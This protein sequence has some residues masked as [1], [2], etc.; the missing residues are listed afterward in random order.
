MAELLKDIYNRDFLRGLG[1][2]ILSVYGSFDAAALA[3]LA[4]GSEWEKTALKA[5]MRKI[6]E[7]LGDLLPD[8]YEDALDILFAIADDCAGFPYLI[9]PDFVA[10]RGQDEADWELSMRALE[11][12]TQK[13]S[14]EFAIRPFIQKNPARV[15]DRMLSWA[16]HPNEHVRRFSSEGCRPR[17][18]WGEALPVFKKDPS[19]VLDILERLKTDG[20]LYVR[21]SVANNLN[22]ISKDNP[23]IVLETARRWKGQSPGADW[24]IRQGCRTLVKRAFPQA[25]SLFGY[26]NSGDGKSAAFD[27][28]LSLSRPEARIGESC[29]IMYEFALR[30]GGPSHIRIEYGVYFIKANGRPSRKLFLLSDKTA[31]GGTSISGTRIHRWANLNTRR[32]YPGDHKITLLVNGLEIASTSLKLLP[33]LCA[34]TELQAKE[35]P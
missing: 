15:M 31:Y 6:T 35:Q 34:G 21:K 1:K 25:M 5:R 14:S 17:L 16:A 10:L 3:G 20:S 29:E 26:E 32:H 24:I 28:K 33:E 4:D 19:P 13:S 9:F 7:S 30:G 22:D 18:P 12:F 23:D 2:K 11:C 8:R 27:A